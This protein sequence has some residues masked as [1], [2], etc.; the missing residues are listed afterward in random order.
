MSN[1]FCLGVTKTIIKGLESG[2]T[3]TSVCKRAGISIRTLRYWLKD[4]A[5]AEFAADVER[6]EAVGT[7]ALVDQI[8]FHSQKDWRAAAW[9]LERTRDERRTASRST[10]AHRKE[11]DELSREKAAAEINFIKA[12]TEALKTSELSPQDIGRIL[13]KA[14]EHR[15]SE[16][17]SVH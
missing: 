7:I 12:K 9:I 14:A 6:A 1:K 11:L 17:D 4:E 3:R 10:A 8:T 16:E 2:H 5:K 15:D 13:G